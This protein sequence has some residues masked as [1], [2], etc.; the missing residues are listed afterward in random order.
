M[1]IAHDRI[2]EEITEYN[3]LKLGAS[4]AKDD[5][6]NSNNNNI[7]NLNYSS[8]MLDLQ[9]DNKDKEFDKLKILDYEDKLEKLIIS[10]SEI[11][12]KNNS[13]M[14]E[15]KQLQEKV[16]ALEN[17][18]DGNNRNLGKLKKSENHNEVNTL[19]SEIERLQELNKDYE[20]SI[21]DMQNKLEFNNNDLNKVR[22]DYEGEINIL[23]IKI[24]EY[25][26]LE[27][28][29]QKLKE[30]IAENEN[31]KNQFDEKFFSQIKKLNSEIKKKN[32]RIEVLTNEL[33][34]SYILIGES[35]R[36]MELYSDDLIKNKSIEKN[37]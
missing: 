24:L 4:F 19:K 6:L 36:R 32:E 30:K 2:A 7:S 20:N 21:S 34:E 5:N 14:I 29:I 37:N 8:S 3:I 9:S 27:N 16:Y 31:E 1:K 15:I 28:L 25:H 10:N 12:K 22:E 23:K 35:K 11:Q 26:K 13:L 17:F 33:S 18:D